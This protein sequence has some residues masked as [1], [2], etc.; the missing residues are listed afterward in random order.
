MV[1]PFPKRVVCVGR[2]VSQ[3][4]VLYETAVCDRSGFSDLILCVPSVC[5]EADHGTASGG[6]ARAAGECDRI[7]GIDPDLI[8]AQN[9]RYFPYDVVCVR[10]QQCIF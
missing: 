7:D 6:M 2:V 5:S 3:P 4:A 10:M 1:Y 9:G 8:C